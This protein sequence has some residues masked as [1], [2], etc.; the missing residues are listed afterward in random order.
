M[1]VTI[2]S[3]FESFNARALG[4]E[5]VARSFI[6]PSQF[7]Q[8][9]LRAHNLI[10]GPRGSGKT[11][12]L[13]MLQPQ[14][15]EAWTR[16]DAE[17]Y[18]SRVDFTAV[19]VATD[20]MWSRQLDALSSAGFEQ[21]HAELLGVAAFATHVFK[22]LVD[23]LAYRCGD[24]GAVHRFRQLEISDD[25]ESV[26]ASELADALGLVIRVP[27]LM[28]VRSALGARLASVMSV[29]STELLLGPEGRAERLAKMPE[30]HLGFLA[31]VSQ[32]LDRIEMVLP[33]TKGERW[34]LLFDELELAPSSLQ[35]T[36]M[37]SLRSVDERLLFKLSVSPY[38][39]D[40]ALLKSALSATPGHDYE[41]VV[42]TYSLK[43]DA[44][45]FCERLFVALVDDR[46]RSTAS[47]TGVLG[48]SAFETPAT[49]WHEHGTAYSVDS[50]LGKLLAEL[51][52]ADS[53]FRKY[54][55][56]NNIDLTRL[57]QLDSDSRAAEVRKVAPLVPIRLAYRS[58]DDQRN[59]TK[60]RLRTRKSPNI[61]AGASSFFA[62][63]LSRLS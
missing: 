49:E 9:V 39:E 45:D 22:S 17:G 50:R 32:C 21:A 11:T 40:L 2:P 63:R 14:A 26:L 62:M 1:R 41:E 46:F 5:L 4:P 27:S 3:P 23:V 58:S 38:N 8:I 30:L 15:L 16:S 19:F 33:Q 25:S 42:L 37:S 51:A 18:R 61:Y 29:A 43:E 55:G 10:I 44:F 34:A 52:D 24:S 59:R 12:L 60:R 47:A 31:G 20:I 57:G 48:P 7:N 35:G 28:G 36:L 6:P 53:S 54:L 13:K 56:Q